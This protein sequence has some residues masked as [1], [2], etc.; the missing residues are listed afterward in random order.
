MRAVIQRTLLPA[1]LKVDNKE[2]SEIRKG[3]IVYL[4][5]AHNDTED[6]LKWLARKIVNLRI[7]NDE[8]D[9]MNLSL[10][11]ISGEILLISQF[12]LFAN[13]KKGNRPSYIRSAE[14]EFANRMYQSFG[15]WIK[16]E[17]QIQLAFGKFG[18]HM[19]VDYT[20][21]GPVTIILD[22]NHKEF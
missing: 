17:Y 15:Q 16:D 2:F 7:F 11:D 18:A 14:P 5:V 9:K 20:N 10:Q 6:D 4:A 22:T 3:L 1:S 19:M 12:T 8:N 13:V 21:D